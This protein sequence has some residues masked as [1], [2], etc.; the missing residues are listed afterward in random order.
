METLKEIWKPDVTAPEGMTAAQ[1]NVQRA[2]LR[3]SLQRLDAIETN[4]GHCKQFEMG[5]CAKHGDVP[6]EF[7]KAADQCPDWTYDAIPF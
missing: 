6:E 2:A 3:Q 5:T 1:L 7:Q 4:C